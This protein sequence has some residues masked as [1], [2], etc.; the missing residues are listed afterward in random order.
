MGNCKDCKH[1]GSGRYIDHD[2]EQVGPCLCYVITGEWSPLD[3]DP[4]AYVNGGQYAE[5]PGE[6]M[7]KGDFGCVLFEG[8]N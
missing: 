7:T 5:G 1:W 3:T 4:L 6:L 2:D 8:A